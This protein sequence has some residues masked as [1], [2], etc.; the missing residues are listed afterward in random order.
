MTSLLDS[1]YDEIVRTLERWDDAPLLQMHA[2]AR[3]FLQPGL[4]KLAS[5]VRIPLQR[6]VISARAFKRTT[7]I[8][9][10]SH[11][12]N[13]TVGDIVVTGLHTRDR[14]VI[15]ILQIVGC[16]IEAPQAFDGTCPHVLILDPRRPDTLHLG[17]RDN[18]V[19]ERSARQIQLLWDITA[20]LNDSALP[21]SQISSRIRISCV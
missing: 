20:I 1:C 11:N 17:I 6:V 18:V 3:I 12:D 21:V 2:V 16:P 15:N 14:K 4:S 19:Q 10:G 7:W 5:P 13:L 8:T 9:V